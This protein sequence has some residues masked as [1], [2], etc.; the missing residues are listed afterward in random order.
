MYSYCRKY[1]AFCFNSVVA[2]GLKKNLVQILNWTIDSRHDRG[3][4]LRFLVVQ[5][6]GAEHQRGGQPHLHEG[7]LRGEEAQGRA[8]H[9]GRH[10]NKCQFNVIQ[11]RSL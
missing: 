4:R 1:V 2:N 8:T 11:L 3:R 5:L 10:V 7:D 9:Q 6:P